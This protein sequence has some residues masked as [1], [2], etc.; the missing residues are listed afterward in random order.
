MCPSSCR[1]MAGAPLVQLPNRLLPLKLRPVQRLVASGCRAGKQPRSGTGGC[2]CSSLA[3][4]PPDASCLPAHSVMLHSSLLRTAP[5]HAFMLSRLSRLLP[6]LPSCPSGSFL[7]VDVHAASPVWE[8]AV[9][10]ADHCTMPF[11]LA[12][13]QSLH[14]PQVALPPLSLRISLLPLP[15]PG[16]PSFEHRFI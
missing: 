8:T 1:T 2:L 11:K 14:S 15:P 9:Q 7:V 12:L 10:C 5:S 6:C 13:F 16:N 3:R 4:S